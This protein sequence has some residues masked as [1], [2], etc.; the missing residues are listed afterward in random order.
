MATIDTFHGSIKNRK[1]V[2]VADSI[3]YDSKMQT[4]FHFSQVSSTTKN[5][6]KDIAHGF[7]AYFKK[8]VRKST[9]K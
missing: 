8:S 9:R 7:F 5:G 2:G 6:H 4:V 1:I 3:R